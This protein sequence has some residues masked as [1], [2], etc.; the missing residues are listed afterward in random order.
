MR[1][2]STPT[3]KKKHR[4]NIWKRPLYIKFQTAGPPM[5]A[6]INNK[7]GPLLH[8]C[9]QYILYCSFL[10]LHHVKNSFFV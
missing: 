4:N 2:L 7:L 9:F 1:Q 3:G 8:Y 6:K 5:D 10:L